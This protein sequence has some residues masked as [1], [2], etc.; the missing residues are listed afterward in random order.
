MNANYYSAH[1]NPLKF[2]CLIFISSFNL[3]MSTGCAS[4]ARTPLNVRSFGATG[5]GKTK[6]TVA[7]QKAI[8][9]CAAAGGREIVVPTG[10][11]LIGSIEL[12]S[13][14]TLRLGKDATLL[15]SP[16]LE[17]YPVTKVR[18]EG[19]WI[20]GHRGLIFA[21][22]AEHI[23]IVGPGHVGACLALGGRQMPRRP[24]VIEP[25]DCH[26]VRL[27]G[28]SVSQQRMWTMHPTYC[29][30]LVV[31]NITIRSIGGNSDG[32]D[33][34]SCKHVRIEGCDI[35]SGDDCI[36]IK[37][38]RGM[39]GYRLART[40]ED[41]LITH[42]TFS[43]NIFACIGIGSETSGGIRDVR[44]EHCKFKQAKTYAIYIKSRPG[45]GAFI[46]DIAARDLEVAVAP[47]GFLRVN[48]LNSGIQ[49]PEPV[50]GDEGV[51]RA[52]N[53]SFT[54]IRV[55]CGTL[56]D[57]ASVSPVKPIDG[58][59]LVNITGSCAK[60]MSLANIRGAELREIQ[61]TGFA[62]PLLGTNN[63]AGSGLENAVP[64]PPAPAPSQNRP[65][66]PPGINVK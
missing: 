32:V 54:D 31:K 35:E 55:S 28:F 20:D 21:N 42:C 45:R 19:R 46:E 7:F 10:N 2:L 61:M 63:V 39:E 48:L 33:V 59:S 5:D 47:G 53:F 3:F 16:D 64:L 62:G 30:N 57:A 6:E 38:G 56:V 8:D 34:D 66:T 13:Q 25:I 58:F 29:E 23:A 14:T 18:W 49:D 27:E 51:P 40:T 50:P 12:K 11:Y 15:G 24:A 60:G 1:M 22:K 26:D 43:D 9:A 41:V 37:S 36:A 4:V 65:A 44:I 52:L 17:D